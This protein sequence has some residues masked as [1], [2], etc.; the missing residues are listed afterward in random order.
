MSETIL[1]VLYFD[2][3]GGEGVGGSGGQGLTRNAAKVSRNSGLS[4]YHTSTATATATATATT[5]SYIH[6]GP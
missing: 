2:Q 6:S 1:V 5:Y 4:S 3:I